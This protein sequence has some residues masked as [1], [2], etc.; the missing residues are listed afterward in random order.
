MKGPGN[1]DD[2]MVR[3]DG[4]WWIVSIGRMLTR[5][6]RVSWRGCRMIVRGYRMLR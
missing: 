3:G 4:N 6:Y 1:G 5:G 2:L